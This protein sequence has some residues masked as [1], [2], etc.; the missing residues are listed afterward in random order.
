MQDA[1]KQLRIKMITRAAID[2][3][4]AA[5]AATDAAQKGGRGGGLSNET[6]EE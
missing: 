4:R 2:Y 1:E 6:G 3:L 5:V